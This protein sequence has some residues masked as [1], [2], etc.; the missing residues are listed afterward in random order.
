MEDTR[1]LPEHI[2]IIMDG[3]GRWAKKR[4]RPREFGHQKGAKVLEDISLYANKLGITYM[5]VYAFSTENWNRPEAEVKALMNLLR[6]YLKG[7][8][9]DSNKNNLKIKVI[10]DRRELPNDIQGLI[11]ELE[12][13]TKD[14]DGMT[15]NIALNYGGRDEILRGIRRLLVDCE[16]ASIDPLNI[17]EELFKQYLDT[18]DT[19][20]P[21]LLIRTSGEQ[22][23]SN[24]LTWQSAYSE[25]YFTDCLWPDFT[26]EAFEKALDTYNNRDRRFGA[27]RT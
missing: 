20:D 11:T 8:I 7:H 13:I 27:I 1:K 3:N 22:R 2:A 10:G 26:E 12:A 5:T 6:R 17:D 18:G 24:F 21:D 4:N 16:Q 23:L 9:K 19:P 25:F 15:L 14:K